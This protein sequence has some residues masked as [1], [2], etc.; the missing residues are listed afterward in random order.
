MTKANSN[1]QKKK[2]FF[3]MGWILVPVII[4]AIVCAASATYF[5]QINF[6]EFLPIVGDTASNPSRGDWGAFGDYFGGVL[7][8][9]FSFLALLV[10]LLTLWQTQKALEFTVE[11]LEL[12]RE[13]VEKSAKAL[14]DQS[15]SLRLQNFEHTFFQY[16]E[17]N[18]NSFAEI[19]SRDRNFFKYELVSIE[20][21]LEDAG[22][23]K[24]NVLSVEADKWPITMSIFR[25]AF[26]RL[27]IEKYTEYIQ[28]MGD[29]LTFVNTCPQENRELYASLIRSRLTKE[30]MLFLFYYSEVN[31]GT[32]SSAKL[33]K[34]LD[35]YGGLVHHKK[36]IF[37]L[38]DRVGIFSD[39]RFNP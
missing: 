34:E 35:V 9:I 12:T 20:E 27:Y 4:I 13:E 28:L 1:L 19:T 2:R 10:L 36:L 26:A 7:N 5:Y 23:K 18:R 25:D 29:F 38:Y 8:P 24:K 16:I 39:S 30:E 11:E 14:E 6:T 33:F 15:S 32:C 31:V 22:A 21:Y 3:S 17:Y 37:P